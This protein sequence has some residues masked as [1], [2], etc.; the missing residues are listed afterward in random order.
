MITL[1]FS[2]MANR[3]ERL[4]TY[5]ASLKIP[6]NIKLQV[7]S[8]GESSNSREEYEKITL[9]CK[10]EKGLSK[11]RN[12]N[13][14]NCATEY[15]WFLD[16]DIKFPEDLGIIIKYLTNF[17]GEFGS[18]DGI[19]CQVQG[20]ET[21]S[22]FKPYHYRKGGG[23]LGK[24]DCLRVSS[25]EIIFSV[26]FL[27]TKSVTFNEKI[28]LGTEYPGNE[29]VNFLIDCYERGADIRWID[30]FLVSHTE[31]VSVRQV[32][33]S[34]VYKIRGATASRF[35][36]IGLLIISRWAFRLWRCP[37]SCINFYLLMLRYY[38][39]GYKWFNS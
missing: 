27:K 20:M 8:Q 31:D 25:I 34:G 23:G 36:P 3:K 4:L 11:S 10:S 29:E 15:I 30:R 35:G 21:G 13:V 26:A 1:A 18:P 12:Y 9:F 2:T 37:K 32:E 17:I 38:C 6:D 22:T 5:L 16:D 39:K 33:G 7:V 19:I 14:S 24:F 28:G